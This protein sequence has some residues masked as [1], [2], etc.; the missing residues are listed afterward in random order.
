[1]D[2]ILD[3]IR[4]ALLA[5]GIDWLITAII[6]FF[7]VKSAT[8]RYYDSNKVRVARGFMEQGL[9]ALLTLKY[10]EDIPASAQAIFVEY[11]GISW[12][13]I[14][15]EKCKFGDKIRK[16]ITVVGG[17]RTEVSDYR[18]RN[19]GVLGVANYLRL[20]VLY[21]FQKKNLYKYERGKIRSISVKETD[22]GYYYLDEDKSKKK[23]IKIFI[24]K[25]KTS[26]DIMIALPLKYNGKMVGGVTFD[27]AVGSKTV[28]QKKE[29]NSTLSE[30]ELKQM[31][32]NNVLVFKNCEQTAQNLITAFFDRKGVYF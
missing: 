7:T 24:S 23:S 26:R 14:E 5:N 2:A 16:T 8:R 31:E 19:Y 28:Y 30:E 3:T 4:Q 6:T 32:D 12:S 21:D 25:K 11:K 9:R 18:P 22:S 1:M 29:D 27:F 13:L 17:N 15:K 10:Y 20:P